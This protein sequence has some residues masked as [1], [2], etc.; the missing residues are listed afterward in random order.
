MPPVNPN[1][2]VKRLEPA[3]SSPIVDGDQFIAENIG[4]EG[5]A[6]VARRTA[7][8][9]RVA[10]NFATSVGKVSVV[11]DTFRSLI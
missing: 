3:Y 1:V 10:A 11:P 4:E 6:D 5:L 7:V 8:F 9:E 2:E